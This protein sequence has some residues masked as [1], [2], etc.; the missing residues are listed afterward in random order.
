MPIPIPSLLQFRAMRHSRTRYPPTPIPIPS[1]PRGMRMDA[2]FFDVVTVR[3]GLIVRIEEYT[4][5]DQA[6][7]AAG[8]E[9]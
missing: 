4:G 3:E 5:R 1:L 8:V 9:E 6:L 2:R 7:E